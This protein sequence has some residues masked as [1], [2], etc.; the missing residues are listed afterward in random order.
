[1]DGNLIEVFVENNCSACKEV[2]DMIHSFADQYCI[3]LRVYD[4]KE[5]QDVFQERTV[6]V[7]PATFV[8]KRLAFY[9]AFSSEELSRYLKNGD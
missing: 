4:R 2:L 1:M 3:R 7:C 5:H 9:G 6:V 8:N